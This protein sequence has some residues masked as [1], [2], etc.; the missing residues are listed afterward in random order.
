MNEEQP[1]VEMQYLGPIPYYLL[2][3][4]Y[5]SILIEKYEHYVK[6]TYRNKCFI[7]GPN[8]ML[9]LTI[10]LEKGKNQNTCI[11]DV[12]IANDN[13]WQSLHW[14]SLCSVY[15]NSPYFEYYE[16]DLAPFYHNSFKFLF[17]FNQQLM[18]QILE[19]LNIS[20]QFS[21]SSKYEKEPIPPVIDW[22]SKI[23]PRQ[24]SERSFPVVEYKQ[25]FEDRTG[26]LPDMSIV[27]LLF[28]EGPH[29]GDM[30]STALSL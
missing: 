13:K 5:P 6:G 10:P 24:S 20:P 25:V 15:R 14:Q 9:R 8:G 21:Y 23:H 3:S 17:D 12:I 19:H 1:L 7:G 22:R 26:F 27:D 18:H 16:D 2:L 11:E 29:A 30:L 4:K 28:A